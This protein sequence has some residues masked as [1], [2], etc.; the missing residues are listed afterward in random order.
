MFNSGSGP[1]QPAPSPLSS[2]N[3]DGYVSIAQKI[4]ASRQQA[5]T[6]T[7]AG[8][9]AGPGRRRPG[10]LRALCA[11]ASFI[12]AALTF[13]RNLLA[14]L[15]MLLLLAVLCAGYYACT[16][17]KEEVVNLASSEAAPP[18]AAREAR[19][20]Y[21]PLR[22]MISERPFSRSRFDALYRK[23]N[24][25]LTGGSSHELLAIERA[26]EL[27]C[28]DDRLEKIVLDLQGMRGLTLSMAGRLAPLLDRLRAQNKEV[29]ATAL[30]YSQP[31]YA[32]ASHASLI[33]LDPMGEVALRGV[34][35]NNLYYRQ[36]L[37]SMMIRPYIFRAGAFKSAVEPFMLGGMSEQ[38][39]S[40]LSDVA[41]KLWQE[42]LSFLSARTQ[43]SPADVLPEAG[44][45][46][47]ELAVYGGDRGRMQQ[48]RHV[49]DRLQST[50]DYLASLVGEYGSDPSGSES[51]PRMVHYT[52]YLSLRRR[53]QTERP[54][55]IYVV[56]G[57]GTIS[58]VSDNGSDFSPDSVLPLLDDIARDKKARAVVFYLNSP[59]GTVSASEL[60]RRKLQELRGRG[61]DVIVS[62]NGTAASGAYMVACAARRI[63]A[64]P[65]TITGSI[66]VFGLGF[67]AD[68]LLNHVGVRQDSVVTHELALMPV[69]TP[70]PRNVMAMLELQIRSV[71]QRFIALVADSRGVAASDYE[72]FAEGR[73][74]MASDARRLQLIDALGSLKDAI[75]LAARDNH[76]DEDDYHVIHATPQT[77]DHLAML[78]Q[79]LGTA[80]SFLLRGS[81]LGALLPE[82]GQLRGLKQPGAND[83]P[84]QAIIPFTPVG[85]EP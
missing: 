26:L 57:I 60:I 73:I 9:G 3:G 54:H 48:V 22:G 80:T 34:G 12:G 65:S 31:A 69:A 66:G 59:G 82:H 19:I 58:D 41:G 85:L 2:A 35:F 79:L 78:D 45:Y 62:M 56:Y 67:G 77:S 49:V 63:L 64:T 84:A 42:Y 83:W 72:R 43:L 14:N 61:I 75:A 21:L 23:L 76:I 10:V 29:V 50:A 15:V 81:A 8:P 16:D 44:A 33:L 68:E 38:V 46:A 40:E 71:Y 6:G 55:H 70:L 18:P 47:Q 13:I 39:R 5:G 37:D 51:L 28:D 53:M 52:D 32:L 4:A 17:L 24:A 27:A 20:L 74:F 25:T 7:A 36:L 11:V 1:R 30:T